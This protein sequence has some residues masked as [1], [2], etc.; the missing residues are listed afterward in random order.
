M[1]AIRKLLIPDFLSHYYEAAIGPFVNLSDLP[2]KDAEMQL[3]HLRQS[4]GTLASKRNADYVSIRWDLENRIRDLFIKKGGKPKRKRPHYMILGNCEWVLSWYQHGRELRIPLCQ[5]SA[6]HISFTY[7]D[8]F[9]AMR[10]PDE[11]SFRGRVYVLSELP[12]IVRKF[13]LPQITN[14]HADSGPERYNEAQIWDDSPL[15]MY[16]KT[17]G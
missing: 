3:A 6:D 7:G 16:L 8:S 13:G 17:K 14:P 11:K 12:G 9:P 4:C 1:D 5:F 10:F 2:Q 15:R